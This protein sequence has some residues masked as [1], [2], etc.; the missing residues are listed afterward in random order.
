M[1]AHAKRQGAASAGW[2][3][4]CE[5]G[6]GVIVHRIDAAEGNTIKTDHMRGGAHRW[7]PG[8]KAE[9]HSHDGADEVFAFLQGSCAI[10]V[11]GEQRVVGAGEF[12][13]VPAEAKHTLENIGDDDLIVFLVV[14]PN[15]HPTHTFYDAQG[16]RTT[17][18]A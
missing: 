9:L 18:R 11:E 2:A 14:A 8:W 7:P 16:Q 15:H 6:Q 10:T 3:A 5:G 4:L 1:T 13:F 17:P 12:V